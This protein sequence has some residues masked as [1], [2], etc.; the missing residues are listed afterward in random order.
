MTIPYQIMSSWNVL[1][2]LVLSVSFSACEKEPEPEPEPELVSFQAEV[3]PILTTYCAYGGCHDQFEEA[4]QLNLTDSAS[5]AEMVNT[6]SFLF[7]GE[8][9][10]EPNDTVNSILIKMI[11]GE[12]TP[13][14]PLFAAAL[15]A[16]DIQTIT[17]WVSEGATNN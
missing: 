7:S 11:K 5:Y 3:Q 14:M 6:A 17:T 4:G 1:A 8:M 15:S 12:E 2:I 16:E 10:I 13:T 9:R